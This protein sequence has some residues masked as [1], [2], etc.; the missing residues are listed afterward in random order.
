SIV[1]GGGLGLVPGVG[2]VEVAAARTMLGVRAQLVVPERPRAAHRLRGVLLVQAHLLLGALTAAGLVALLPASTLLL[3]DVLR[4]AEGTMW[5]LPAAP[6]A[7]AGL[8]AAALLGIVAGLGLAV[9]LGA[10]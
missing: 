5:P 8:G 2:E 1:L 7:R 6:A 4:G 3:V 10:L 9:P